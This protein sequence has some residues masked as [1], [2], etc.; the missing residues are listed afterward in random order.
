MKPLLIG[1][2]LNSLSGSG[3]PLGGRIGRFLAKLCG[4]TYSEYLKRFER[5]NV[6][7]NLGNVKRKMVG[8]SC[9]VFG[10]EAS[11]ILGLSI[12]WYAADSS[13]KIYV[14][15]HPSGLNRM[16]NNPNNR[17]AARTILLHILET[18]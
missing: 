7:P 14:L 10:R 3:V 18:H 16:Y 9:V 4:Q 8:R 5:I 11:R 12:S 6:R 13:G 2:K 15:P 17:Q 1:L